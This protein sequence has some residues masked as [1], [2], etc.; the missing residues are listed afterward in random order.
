MG[1]YHEI[2]GADCVLIGDL[3][4]IAMQS[5]NYDRKRTQHFMIGM[6]QLLIKGVIIELSYLKLKYGDDLYQN[7]DIKFSAHDAFLE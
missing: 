4:Q 7:V 5:F 1:L 3:L 2:M 6:L